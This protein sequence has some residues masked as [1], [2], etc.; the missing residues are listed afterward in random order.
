[1]IYF[2]IQDL[3]ETS[4]LNLLSG[5]LSIYD[6]TVKHIKR[7]RRQSLYNCKIQKRPA[8][9]KFKERTKILIYF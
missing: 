6:I 8:I 7:S 3:M 5:E 2:S 1:M 9:F 4:R